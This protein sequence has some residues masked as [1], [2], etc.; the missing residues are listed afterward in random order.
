MFGPQK[1]AGP[2][3]VRLLGKALEI[4]RETTLTETGRDMGDTRFAGAAGGLAGGLWAYLGAQLVQGS[5]LV[6]DLV[7]FDDQAADSSL[8]ITG[9]GALDETTWNGKVVH[10]V[11]QRCRRLGVPVV[12]LCG[13]VE[14]EDLAEREGLAGWGSIAPG[15]ASLAES[16]DQASLW[17]EKASYRHLNWIDI[18]TNLDREE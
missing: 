12:A 14:A 2:R 4:F 18:G 7:G 5:G 17:L 3:E 16:R 9:E 6:C 15:P 13:Q 10:Q 11:V 1:G 8:V